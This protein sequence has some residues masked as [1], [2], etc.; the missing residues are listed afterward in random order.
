MEDTKPEKIKYPGLLN[1]LWYD[2]IWSKVIY[3][4]IIALVGFV[5]T[6]VRTLW[7]EKSFYEVMME[8]L[9]YQLRL[10]TIL[11]VVAISLLIYGFL[12]WYRSKK[13]K[14]DGVFDVTQKVGNYT[15]R[16]LHNALLSYEVR[17]PID[18]I[19]GGGPDA[20]RYIDL[21]TCFRVYIRVFNTG[22]DWDMTA[23]DL[24]HT[25]GPHLMSYGLIE[26]VKTDRDRNPLD[27]PILQTSKVG[28]EFYAL[29]E[30]FRVY[31]ERLEREKEGALNTATQTPDETKAD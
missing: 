14:K 2:P 23:H 22:V 21:L 16:E 19:R 20:P 27:Q 3:V 6:L 29:L 11:I 12:V 4:S 15:F 5:W 13:S 1:K 31:N 10:Y 30:R 25:I 7:A 8:T 9:T 24:Y 17:T 28:F 18:M 26:Q